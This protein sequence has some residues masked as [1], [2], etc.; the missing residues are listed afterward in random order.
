MRRYLLI[1]LTLVAT[2]CF[3]QDQR[4]TGGRPSGSRIQT[5]TRTVSKFSAME[6]NLFQAL[7]DN[8]KAAAENILADDFESWTAEKIPPTPR[9]EWVQM[10][11]GNLKSFRMHNMAVREFGDT[12]VVSFLLERTGAAANGKTMS[13]V[14]FI[15][16]VWRGE[17][18]AV[19]YASAP[20]NPASFQSAPTGKE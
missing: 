20:A 3:A 5:A 18:L 6:S 13:P 2:V 16:D 19:R 14:L 7:Q 1:C 9:S 11:V 12:S 4:P 17:K 10:S 8:N 15:V